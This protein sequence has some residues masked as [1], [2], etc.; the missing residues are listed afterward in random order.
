M[1]INFRQ[2][3]LE[4]KRIEDILLDNVTKQT[5]RSDP[6]ESDHL[7]EIDEKKH[8]ETLKYLTGIKRLK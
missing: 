2:A 6:L 7:H 3:E 5:E 4:A 8:S 1:K